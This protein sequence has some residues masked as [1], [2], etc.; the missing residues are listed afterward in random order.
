M[1]S[2]RPDVETRLTDI[3]QPGVGI[4]N[5]VPSGIHAVECGAGYPD[6]LW[7]G[8]SGGYP[9]HHVVEG[10]RVKLQ[11]QGVGWRWGLDDDIF[12]IAHIIVKGYRDMMKGVN[13][14]VAEVD[15]VDRHESGVGGNVGCDTHDYTA[16]GYRSDRGIG[17]HHQEGKLQPGDIHRAVQFGQHRPTVVLHRRVLS[18]C[19]GQADGAVA[20]ET[21]YGVGIGEGACCAYQGG[22]APVPAAAD[23]GI[24]PISVEL[25]VLEVGQVGV[26][27]RVALGL[28][29]VHHIHAVSSGALGG[30]GIDV[31]RAV[32]KAEEGIEGVGDPSHGVGA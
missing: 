27:E 24:P 25:K 10:E 12:P 18:S 4:C 30:N 8:A 16:M 1:G 2:D 5:S 15:G 11:I 17:A 19:K 9:Q 13:G 28:N 21:P 7:S 26:G 20:D 29:A 14:L 31:V 23:S 22:H 3:D 6:A 32:G